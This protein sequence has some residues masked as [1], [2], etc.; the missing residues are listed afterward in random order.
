MNLSKI[1]T[2]FI[3]STF[4]L[5]VSTNTVLAADDPCDITIE[6]AKAT[7]PRAEFVA[8]MTANGLHDVSKYIVRY[9]RGLKLEN[10]AEFSSVP[11]GS[12]QATDKYSVQ[13]SRNTTGVTLRSS[14]HDIDRGIE[15]FQ[16]RIKTLCPNGKPIKSTELSCIG[17]SPNSVNNI[18]KFPKDRANFP[19][20]SYGGGFSGK[21]GGESVNYVI[22][23]PINAGKGTKKMH[24]KKKK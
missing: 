5:L 17:K 19:Y 4:I 12:Q 21:T 16:E 2:H 13:W 11:A 14:Y 23:N 6:G 3:F 7:M 15:I 8:V 1:V 20:C 24:K 9:T 18:S 22:S 10:F